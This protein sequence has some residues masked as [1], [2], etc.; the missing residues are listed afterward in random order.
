[1]WIRSLDEKLVNLAV[2]EAVE[3]VDVFPDDASAE[4]IDA[5]AVPP[6]AFEVVAYLPG[7]W[8]VPLYG[9]EHGDDAERALS[10]LAGLLATD[11]VSA[12]LGGGRVRALEELMERGQGAGR[13]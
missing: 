6:V 11:G 8:E 9:S 1:M 2:T 13:N 10:F 5:G 4:A 7:G 3:V 12:T